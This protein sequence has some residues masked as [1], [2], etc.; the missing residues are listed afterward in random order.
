MAFP[1]PAFSMKMPPKECNVWASRERITEPE[2]FIRRRVGRLMDIL[3][4]TGGVSTRAYTR[5]Q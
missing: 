2:L 1:Q 4:R 5:I 3:Y